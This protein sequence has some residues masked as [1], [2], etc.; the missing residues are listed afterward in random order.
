MLSS[1]N[2]KVLYSYVVIGFGWQIPKLAVFIFISVLMLHYCKTSTRLIVINWFPTSLWFSVLKVYFKNSRLFQFWTFIDKMVKSVSKRGSIV[3]TPNWSSF[4]VLFNVRLKVNEDKTKAL[5]IG[6][7]LQ[8]CDEYY[9]DWDQNSIN[10][11]DPGILKTRI[12]DLNS[13][14]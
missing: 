9:L 2:N 1:V 8:M 3:N 5:R 6:S 11:F 12:W 13:V 7:E 14:E 4:W 10:T